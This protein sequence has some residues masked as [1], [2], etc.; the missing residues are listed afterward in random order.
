[1]GAVP[2]HVPGSADSVCPCT[3]VP[4]IVGSEVFVGGE[5]AGAAT[6]AV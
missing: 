3:A 5:A 4:E 2:L 6:T 1:M